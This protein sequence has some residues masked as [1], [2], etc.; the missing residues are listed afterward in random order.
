[1][2]ERIAYFDNASTSFPK[3]ECVYKF[4]DEFYRTS[5]VNIGR[6]QYSLAT[7]VQKLI[8]STRSSLLDLYC[9]CNKQV[10]FTSSATEAINKILLGLHITEDSNIYLSPFEHNAVSRVVHAL[11]H[12]KNLS[13][14]IIPFDSRTLEINTAE[15]VRDFE[16]HPP[17]LVVMT[18]VSNVC[19]AILPVEAVFFQAKKYKAVTVVDMSQSA[20]LLNLNVSSDDIDY[21]VFAGHKTLYASFGIGGF[22][23]KKDAKLNPIIFG[24]NGKDSANQN[25]TGTLVDLIEV[26][27]QNVYAIA[28]LYASLMWLM[29]KGFNWVQLKEEENAKKLLDSLRGHRNIEIIADE[30]ICAR[31]GIASTRFLHYSPDEIGNFLN[32]AGIAVRTGLH[33]SPYAHRFLNSSP[34][35]TVRFSISCFTNNEDFIKL[36]AALALIENEG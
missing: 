23:C 7:K 2:T 9:C 15:L 11:A 1:M 29:Q 31:T 13:V 18:H 28:S 20:G 16:K 24:G 25:A 26:G 27:S 32:R 8:D 19:G 10:L 30:M 33:C 5:G 14:K 17:N 36:N 22:Y 12:Q 34:D 6:G 4:A 3:P 21:A 35:G